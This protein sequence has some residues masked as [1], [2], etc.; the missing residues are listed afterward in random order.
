MSIE[1]ETYTA[2]CVKRDWT[3]RITE[4]ENC[5]DAAGCS[6]IPFLNPPACNEANSCDDPTCLASGWS[7]GN[8][9]W[10]RSLH[11]RRDSSWPDGIPVPS[12]VG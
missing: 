6:K 5:A 11:D 3:V 2:H 12:S 8:R 7:G 9:Y 1:S 10:E 4:S